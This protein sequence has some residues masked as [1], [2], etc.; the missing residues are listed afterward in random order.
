MD[1]TVRSAKLGFG[2][3]VGEKGVWWNYCLGESK[4]VPKLVVAMMTPAGVFVFIHCLETMAWFLCI[5]T[6]K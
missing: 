6:E 5:V 2:L 4:Y 1:L 3:F